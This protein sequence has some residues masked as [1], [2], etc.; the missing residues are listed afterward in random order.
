[1]D[2]YDA[3]AE[4]AFVLQKIDSVKI[5]AKELV[6]NART[7]DDSLNCKCFV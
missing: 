4:V 6:D 7:L 1:M 3:A 5:Y 2:L